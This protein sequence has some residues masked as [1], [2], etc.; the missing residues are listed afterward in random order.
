[1]LE[2]QFWMSGRPSQ[3]R[4]WPDS[5]LYHLGIH[6]CW[7]RL[8]PQASYERVNSNG[9][10]FYVREQYM[11]GGIYR[12]PNLRYFYIKTKIPLTRSIEYNPSIS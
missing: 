3:A 6:H 10:S 8:L 9:Y 5:I 2:Q 12:G 1:M 7:V 11:S 4:L